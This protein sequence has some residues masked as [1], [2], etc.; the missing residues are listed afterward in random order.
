M[1]HIIRQRLKARLASDT[2][3]LPGLSRMAGFTLL[4]VLVVIAIIGILLTI[5]TLSVEQNSR[6]VLQQ[7]AERLQGLLQLAADEAILSGRELALQIDP[8]R[9]L[10]MRLEGEN[11]KP[12]EADRILRERQLP[13]N[14]HLELQV[15][16]VA[17]DMFAEQQPRRIFILSSGEMTPFELLLGNQEEGEY[18][19]QGDITGKLEL[20]W[21][22]ENV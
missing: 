8:D 7:E 20:Y 10:F 14:I 1:R 13:V 9:Y 4:E 5:A 2:Q 19:L 6:N 12:L 3:S 15:E 11:W 22:E 18:I 16:G 17:V 21:S